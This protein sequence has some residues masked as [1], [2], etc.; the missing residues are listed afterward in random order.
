MATAVGAVTLGEAGKYIVTV[1]ISAAFTAHGTINVV[2]LSTL[3]TLQPYINI[4]TDAEG[5]P[6]TTLVIPLGGTGTFL[7]TL[8]FTHAAVADDEVITVSAEAFLG[9]DSQANQS[10][11]MTAT[12][13][14][15]ISACPFSC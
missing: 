2:D 6:G 13:T 10:G 11:A 5:A 9:S 4:T 3:S 1:R 7:A 14:T 12:V 8:T 15:S